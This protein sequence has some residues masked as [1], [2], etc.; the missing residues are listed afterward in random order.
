MIYLD[1]NGTTPI[2][3]TVR[4]VMLPFLEDAF[5]NPSSMCQL[6]REAA[7][8]LAQARA[9]VAALLGARS[10]EIIFTSGAT[11]SIATAFHCALTANPKKHHIVTCVTE[12]SATL[13][14]C[15]EYASRGYEITLLPVNREGMLSLEVLENALTPA[16]ALISLLWANNE[17]G[18]IFPI[19]KIA[20]IAQQKKVPLHLDAVQ[21]VGKIPID[22]A[23]F[24]VDYLSLAGH[25]FYAPKG[26]GALYVHRHAF[27]T[28][29]FPGS[30]EHGR[31]GGTEN[32]PAIVALG[33]A[34]EL[35]LQLLST[36]MTREAALRDSLEEELFKK[37]DSIFL[38]GEKTNRLSN[39]SNFSFTGIQA[40][41]A[42]LLLDQ[43]GVCCSA[44]SA[45]NTKSK[46]P[47]HVL[48]A[49]R[50]TLA[51]A[52]SSLRFSLGRFTTQEEIDRVLEIIPRVVKKLRGL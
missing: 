6:G 25:K 3:P 32:I 48:T 24:S 40:A 16:T 39:T 19:E 18:V 27:Y 37:I 11:E 30:Q 41:E 1:Y 9:Q 4:A 26:I 20:A 14:C 35:A 38:N 31:R 23:T 7:A 21:A 17:S 52:R 45:C 2:D 46:T 28:P 49:M 47:S 50:L 10:S 34:A 8:A 42:L 44:G 43:E 5:G 12:H 29:L 33:K 36:E 15:H 13:K 22:L 51:E